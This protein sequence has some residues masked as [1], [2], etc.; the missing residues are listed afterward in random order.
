MRYPDT[1]H[2]CDVCLALPYVEFHP[3]PSFLQNWPEILVLSTAAMG[4]NTFKADRC[5]FSHHDFARGTLCY[6]LN[7]ESLVHNVFV[8]S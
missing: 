5:S 6:W 3:I 1:I 7:R 2:S 4:F 8:Y